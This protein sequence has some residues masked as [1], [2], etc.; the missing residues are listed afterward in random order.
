MFNSS[1]LL[2]FLCPPIWYHLHH[3]RK[4]NTYP[5][6][7]ASLSQQDRFTTCFKNLWNNPLSGFRIA[8]DVLGLISEKLGTQRK[9][10][11]PTFEKLFV[12]KKLSVGVGPN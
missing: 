12:V 4:L 7:T 1:P 8:E 5:T 3:R 9:K 11:L 6:C 2:N 10:L